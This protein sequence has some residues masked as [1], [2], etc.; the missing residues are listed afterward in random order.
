MLPKLT[1]PVM[2]MWGIEDRVI[3]VSTVDKMKPLLQNAS[4]F[5]MENT[6]HVP[7]I[8]KPVETAEM[9]R[10]FLKDIGK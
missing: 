7:M 4:Y 10:S 1:I 2:V 3:D 5:V 6:G 9:Y 8:E